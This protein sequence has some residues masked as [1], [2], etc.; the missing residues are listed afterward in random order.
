M[1]ART[2]EGFA[3][4]TSL[5][6]ILDM[7]EATI[8]IKPKRGATAKF[9]VEIDIEK[10]EKLASSLGLFSEDFI[11]SLDRAE[12]DYEAGRVS[13]AKSLKDLRHK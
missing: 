7:S 4:K 10:F 11:K 12:A 13:K 2:F 3:I 5:S 6:Y 9:N 1:D 8:S